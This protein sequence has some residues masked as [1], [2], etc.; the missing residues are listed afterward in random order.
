MA[1]TAGFATSAL[2]ES[3][4]SFF[5]ANAL[6]YSWMVA[7]GMDAGGIVECRKVTDRTGNGRLRRMSQGIVPL[8]KHF[9]QA[10]G[11]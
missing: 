4:I 10:A 8:R 5:D 2:P 7:F 3:P 1:L 9:R 6:L 11:K